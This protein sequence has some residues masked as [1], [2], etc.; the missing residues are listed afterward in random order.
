MF[1]AFLISC[2]L[3]IS[4]SA[5]SHVEQQNIILAD[6]PMAINLD[7]AMEWF[8]ADHSQLSLG[9]LQ[10]NGENAFRPVKTSAV[11]EQGEVY[12]VRFKIINPYQHSI[13]LALTLAP[14]TTII[15]SAYTWDFTSWKRLP[16]SN[17]RHELK[18]HTGL[19]LNA[20]SQSELWFY[21]RVK[22]PQTTKLDAK[23]QDLASYTED[24]NYL[25]RILG[26]S[27]A[28][29][30][31]IFLLHLLATRFHNH[32]RHY[33]IM[34]M[35]V[36]ITLYISSQSPILN[37][38]SWLQILSGLMP[39]FLACGLALSSFN[40]HFYHR[41]LRSTLSFFVVLGLI[42]CTLILSNTSY[43]TVLISALVPTLFA[44]VR[45]RQ[46]SA[47]LQLACIVMLVDLIWQ[48]AYYLW[49]FDVYSPSNFVDIYSTSLICL[50]VSSS[51]IIPYF[52]RQI[53]KQRPANQSYHSEFLSSLSHELRT[54]IN[55]V[56][57]MSE[58]LADTPLSSGQRDYLE[59][60][61]VSG[62]DMLR[63]INRVSDYA[64]LN[65]GRIVINET[66]FDIAELAEKNLTKFQH[67]AKQRQIELVLNLATDVPTRISSD[68]SRLHT[69]LENLLENAMAQTEHGEIELRIGLSDANTLAIS[70]RDTGK[71]LGKETLKQ[72][73]SKQMGPL[74]PTDTGLKGADFALTLCKRLI[75]AMGGTLY[76]ESNQNIGTSITFNLP[77]TQVSQIAEEEPQD[78]PLKG[79]SILVVDDNST[80]RKVI[81]QYAK[82]WGAKADTTF[83]GKEALA[84]LRS[85]QHLD[86][87]YDIILIDQDMPIMDGFQ[88]AARIH[89][90]PEI[91]PNLIKVMLTGMGIS[92]N[93]NV[94]RSTGI[95]QVITKPVSARALKQ[96]LS[97]HIRNKRHEKLLK[98]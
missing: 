90:D 51:M 6:G 37:W 18:G 55:G 45:A 61:Q 87:P 94:V 54:P 47:L 1:R 31:F 72:L 92:S 16:N 64:K 17:G 89:D 15:E 4:V 46:I 68:H 36:V 69:I 33:L 32:V 22:A 95:H 40:T 96:V 44:V 78:N 38:P 59:T 67:Q 97:Q 93:H 53:R 5:A 12:W 10:I 28:I 42:L 77:F 14:N 35:A 98:P 73:M 62:Q 84:L 21:F 58:L 23:L 83:S 26:A 29:A 3:L 57:G 80:L 11:L 48:A 2:L 19:M 66:P 24:I 7:H 86:A 82:S 41:F 43:F 49:P 70:I 8:Q 9:Q 13:P 52:Q 75:E 88:L 76:V 39:W 30:A 65:A 56:L 91:N 63:L 71:G 34:Y 79:L 20:P 60:I 50:L 74:T 25:Q 27:Q 85:Q 81:Q